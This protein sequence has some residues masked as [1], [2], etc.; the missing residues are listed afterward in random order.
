MKY[1]AVVCEYNPF[2]NGHLYQIERIKSVTNCDGIICV[3]SGD[4]VQRAEP[5]L[6]NKYARA[7]CALLCGADI[8]VE[9]PTVYAIANGAKFAQGA[10]SI[11]KNL[12]NVEYLA[13]GCETND[14]TTLLK[15]AQIQADESNEFKEILKNEMRKGLSYA[16]S[17]T[18]ATVAM[19]EKCG[20]SSAMSRTILQKPN[21]LLCIE[22]VKALKR[23]NSPIEPVFIQRKG[24]EHNAIEV[25]SEIASATAIREMYYSHKPWETIERYIPPATHSAVKEALRHTPDLHTYSDLVMYTLKTTSK[26]AFSELPEIAEGIDNK[27]MQL[28]AKHT[29]YFAILQEVK[30]KRYTMSRLKRICLHSVLRI[31]KSTLSDITCNYAHI[32]GIRE[33]FKHYLSHLPDQF[34][35][36]IAD[37]DFMDASKR[38][39]YEIDK[40]ASG[41]YSLLTHNDT[42]GYFNKLMTV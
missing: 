11:I 6:L 40:R 13:M 14:K 33:H 37:C 28:A 38:E 32:L 17:Y 3:M 20:I 2:H 29:D 9:L 34:Y 8:V 23:V 41:I 21:N 4:F 31:F 27:I 22:Y 10:I 36:Q 39:L 25:S 16:Q 19:G 42:Y 5:A 7:K 26:K 35:V 12:P 18:T 24:D 1:C 15:L 30:S